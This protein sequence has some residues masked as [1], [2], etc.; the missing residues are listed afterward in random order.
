MYKDLWQKFLS[1]QGT[2]SLATFSDSIDNE[3][4]KKIVDREK[5][6]IL[7]KEFGDSSP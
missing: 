4:Y 1:S 2:S 5:E 7:R 6:M 3:G